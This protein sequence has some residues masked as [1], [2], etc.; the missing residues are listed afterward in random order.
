MVNKLWIVTD[1]RTIGRV[2]AFMADKNIFIADGHHRYGTAM[3]YRDWLHETKGGSATDDAEENKVLMVFC[4]MEDPGSL[5]LPTHRVLS[6]LDAEKLMALWSEGVSACDADRADMIIFDG[7][8]G[9]RHPV[10]FTNRDI[11]SKLEPDKSTHWRSLDVAYLHRYLVG[12]LLGKSHADADVQV[13][14][15]KVA[16]QAMDTSRQVKG[17]ALLMNGTPLDQLKGVSEAGELM[18]QKTTFFH[19]KLATGMVMHAMG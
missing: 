17:S 6:G 14:Y 9:K 3:M 11:L 13:Q 15:V 4:A 16:A 18:P 1:G 2:Q 12:E 19:P 8:S 10:K 7:P 5:I